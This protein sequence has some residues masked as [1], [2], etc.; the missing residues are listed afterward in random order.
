MRAPRL[1]AP[2]VVQSSAMDC[3]P[4]AL[5]ALLEGF[6]V[7][8]PYGR[9]R[10]ACQTD[11][12]GTSIDRLEDVA[13]AL[14]LDVEQV[15]IPVDHALRDEAAALPALAAVTLPSGATHFVVLWRT[16]GPWVQVM[17][18][19]SGRVWMR[20]ETLLGQLYVHGMLA[21]AS[22]WRAWAGEAEFVDVL[23]ARLRDLGCRRGFVD[24]QVAEALADPRWE[25]LARLDAAARMLDDLIAIDAL[26]RGA[27]VEGALV[28]LIAESRAD[29]RWIP[30]RCRSA[31]AL[32]PE[33]AAEAEAIGEEAVVVRGAVLLRVLGVRD[34]A[35]PD[36]A[37]DA[38]QGEDDAAPALPPSLVGA[39][40]DAAPRPGR[41]LWRMIA[42][43]G[44]LRPSL[45]VA[46]IAAASVGLLLEAAL[47]RGLVELSA[48]LGLPR[49]RLVAWAALLLFAFVLLLLEATI[50]HELRRLGRRLEIRLRAA[51][52]GKVPR[53]GARY[54]QSR[55]SSDMAE[56]LHAMH[57]LRGLP[58]LG[59]QLLRTTATLLLTVAG[60]AWLD[61]GAAVIAGA[62]ALLLIAVALLALPVLR[63]RDLRL[64]S[65][66]GALSRVYLDALLGLWPIR[67]HGA[68]RAVRREHEEL[69][70]EWMRAGV[71]LLRASVSVELLQAV[72][73]MVAVIAVVARH[74]LA[75]GEIGATLLLIYWSMQ[76]PT[77]GQRVGTL[78][79][80]YPGH[81]SRALRLFEP[82]GAPDEEELGAADPGAPALPATG[83]LALR[84]D[85]VAVVAGGHVLLRGVTLDVAAGE[86]VAVVGASGA[87]KSTLLGALLGWHRP[88]RGRVLVGGAPLDGPRLAALRERTAWI[89]PSV[90]LWNE[91][92][93]DNLLYG[94]DAAALDEI[95]DALGDADLL[96][97]VAN[98]PDGL[99]TALGEGGAAL[100]GGEGQRVR[101]G[102]ALLRQDVGLVLLDEALRGLDHGRRAALL[103][104]LRARWAG[105]TLLCATHDIA[106]TLEFPRVIVVDGGR[107]VADGD[108]KSLAHET[109][110]YAQMLAQERAVQRS[111]WRRPQWRR[112]HLADGGIAV[113]EAPARPQPPRCAP[114]EAPA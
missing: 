65:H 9:L 43:D 50:V 92:L 105:A 30:E 13:L 4:A 107:V 106:E 7:H 108:P 85:G 23:R 28:T 54:F 62:G 113:D 104:R 39:R 90:A 56:R 74:T 82:L 41:A 55:L 112:V 70:V 10:E 6:G 58:G 18:P 99:Q 3:G 80:Q 64:R 11:V 91:A 46:A 31:R 52:L 25:A 69:L 44:L 89:D 98:L 1:F 17:N 102:R 100:S 29:E 78:L 66:A 21:P 59:G 68:A 101:L 26:R 95:G 111:M 57:G 15:V 84:F 53:L 88:A 38:A 27:E 94:A 79:R 67:A 48:R 20:R 96:G 76:L 77:L 5:S 60:V 35:A 33:A 49:E 86:H 114:E 110:P 47:L 34:R 97:L 40:D 14:G 109:G 32:P 37:G 93:V 63:E 24:A 72:V 83:A 2:E 19:S 45:I 87:G 71:L 75:A 16:F 42:A 81:R 22:A 103:R 73:G 36:R 61:A 51:F 12:D 8:V